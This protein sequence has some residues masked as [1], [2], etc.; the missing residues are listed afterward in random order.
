MRISVFLTQKL[1]VTKV[2]LPPHRERMREDIRHWAWPSVNECM[3]KRYAARDGLI[4]NHGGGDDGSIL[5]LRVT[6]TER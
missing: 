6:D 5:M 2:L 1:Q 3:G 4:R